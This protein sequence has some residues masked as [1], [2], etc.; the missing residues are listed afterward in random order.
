MINQ[1]SINSRERWLINQRKSRSE[2]RPLSRR[3][4]RM[5]SGNLSQRDHHR[6]AKNNLQTP[7]LKVKLQESKPNPFP[8]NRQHKSKVIYRNLNKPLE[9]P[10]FVNSKIFSHAPR[11]HSN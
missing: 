7:K 2:Y 10:V 1:N 11:K 9:L 3:L 6:V 8:F 5:S 4:E